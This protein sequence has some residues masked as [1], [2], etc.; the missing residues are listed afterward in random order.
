MEKQIHDYF[1][2]V[3]MPKDCAEQ[4]ETTLR[5]SGK[6]STPRRIPRPL[7]AAAML[8]LVLVA[9]LNFDSICTSATSFLES[10][11]H[12]LNPGVEDALDKE[13]GQVED[14]LY[15]GYN[16]L[17]ADIHSNSSSSQY[18]ATANFLNVENG[19]MYFV[20]N[21]ECIDITDK[22]SAEVAYVYALEDNTGVIHFLIAGGTPDNY[23][24]AEFMYD[25]NGAQWI[26]GESY[27]YLDRNNDWNA[28]GWLT[29]AKEK[30]GFPWSVG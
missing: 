12:Q 9:V 18:S 8:A 10:I 7:A 15:V 28:Y 29:D 11:T 1:D 20:G 16:G 4:I 23:G 17:I 30:T 22:C 6:R 27:N 14:G 19:R 5:H 24:Y 26:A 25:P 13:I 3:T 2:S 21:G